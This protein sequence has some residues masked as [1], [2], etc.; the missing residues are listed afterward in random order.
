[1]ADTVDSSGAGTIPTIFTGI[2]SNI[3]PYSYQA[4][5]KKTA[6]PGFLYVYVV[7]HSPQGGGNGQRVLVSPKNGYV[8]SSNLVNSSPGNNFFSVNRS[9]IT[10]ISSNDPASSTLIFTRTPCTYTSDT[11]VTAYFVAA[12]SGGN[13]VTLGSTF[14]LDGSQ[15]KLTSLKPGSYSISVNQDGNSSHTIPI[16]NTSDGSTPGPVVLSP[17]S[18]SILSLCW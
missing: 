5:I 15:N 4:S 9:G 3:T 10:G 14:P 17:G 18:T 12:L 16:Y 1:V 8:F 11:N 6:G 13:S 7:A 2:F